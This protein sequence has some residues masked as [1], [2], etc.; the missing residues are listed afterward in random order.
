MDLLSSAQPTTPSPATN[1]DPMDKPH[2]AVSADHAPLSP[3]VS[4]TF[5]APTFPPRDAKVNNYKKPD[6]TPRFPRH[7][8]PTA[9]YTLSLLR[10]QH[11]AQRLFGDSFTLRNPITGELLGPFAVLSYTD[12][13]IP[14]YCSYIHSI[15]STP[16]FTQ[17]ER[18]LI[19]LAVASVT[20]A[21]YVMY[22]HRRIAASVGLAGETIESALARFSWMEMMDLTPREKN[23]YRIA[24]EMAGDWGRVGD[25]TWAA[26]VVKDKPKAKGQEG[27]LEREF[28][29]V[30]AVTVETGDERLTRGEV[31]MLAQVLASTMF[32]SVLVNCADLDI[33]SEQEIVRQP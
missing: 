24:S 2:L 15:V 3:P 17:R 16:T 13:R 25:D 8:C 33:G 4:P 11:Q 5:A 28:I 22:A 29:D 9:N 14:Q 10:S 6:K 19:V 23:V 18:E 21:E 30:D 26:V 20:R 31:A 7:P 1:I 27:W 32:V 12:G